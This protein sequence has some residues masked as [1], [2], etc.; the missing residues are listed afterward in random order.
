MPMTKPAR[1]VTLWAP[2][3]LMMVLIFVLSSMP[4]DPEDHGTLYVLSRKLAHFGEYA[5][6]AALWWRALVTR[7]PHRR[8][9]TLA[10]LISVAYAVT[11]E[12]HQTFESGRSG[13]PLDVVIDTAGALAAAMLIARTR[14]RRK[15]RA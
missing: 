1:Q 7:L 5:L 14:R 6:L 3:I 8:A 10:V 2:P 9:L 13:R 12:F 15:A 11:D 4:A